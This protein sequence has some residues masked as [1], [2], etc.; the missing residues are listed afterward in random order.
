M[1]TDTTPPKDTKPFLWSVSPTT[2]AG[3]L[4]DV[5]ANQ[6]FAYAAT[7][8]LLADREFSVQAA[9][10][11]SALNLKYHTQSE[12]LHKKILELNKAREKERQALVETWRQK[13][14]ARSK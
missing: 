11:L 2:L 8:E 13:A 9:E 10:E 4:E 6:P 3:F 7:H 12:P 1:T 14:T 5:C